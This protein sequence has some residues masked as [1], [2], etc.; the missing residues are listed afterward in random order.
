MGVEGERISGV[1]GATLDPGDMVR[2]G[3][4]KYAPGESLV[5]VGVDGSAFLNRVEGMAGDFFDGT[6]LLLWTP[7]ELVAARGLP[8]AGEPG[9]G[10]LLDDFEFLEETDKFLRMPPCFLRLSAPALAFEADLPRPA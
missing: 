4:E 9:L 6:V 1:M 2:G 10:T 3:V 5:D 7:P 8:G